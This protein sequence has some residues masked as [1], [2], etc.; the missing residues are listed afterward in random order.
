M[1]RR[2]F[3][4]AVA[5]GAV[6]VAGCGVAYA[7]T[8][9]ASGSYRTAAV[10]L[11]DVDETV[12]L[13]GT[14]T[15]SARRDLSFGV[16]GT[17]ATVDVAAG[18]VVRSGATLAT[19]DATA[20]RADVTQARAALAKAKAQL[21][22]DQTSQA[23]TVTAA[24]SSSEPATTAKKPSA[25]SG[26]SKDSSSDAPSKGA[27][28]SPALT[29]ALARL[30]D[31]QAVVTTAQTAATEAIAAAKSA[32]AAQVEACT[33]AAEVTDPEPAD[34]EEP[35][36]VDGTSLS[37]E[38]TDALAS[39]QDAQDVVAAKQDVL[40]SA[41]EKLTATLTDAVKTV[42]AS[43]T[44]TGDEQQSSDTP[45][46]APETTSPTT[47]SSGGASEDSGAGGGAGTG[48]GGGATVTA[49]TLAKDQAAIDTARAQLAEAR[50]Q[51][52]A[53]DLTA[54]FAGE[55]LSVTV[56]PGDTVGASDAV[57]VMVGDGSTT[58]T[59]TVTLDQVSDI[60]KGQKAQVTPAGASA[61]VTGTV[62]EIGLL[63]DT[64]SETSTFPVT[65]DL[66]GDVAAPE[67]STAAISL[68]VG[69]ASNVLTVPSSAVTTTGRTMV[70]V[71]QDGTP[72]MT[73]VTVGVV[74]QRRTEITDG[75]DEGQVVVLA[76]L[77][78]SL[79][80][81][82]GSTTRLP[83]SGSGFGGGGGVPGGAR[84]QGGGRG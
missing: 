60:A 21:E 7:Q 35:A 46:A 25:S 62:T 70:T 15:A 59:T 41:L 29:K 22:S 47:G 19:L 68:V 10:A 32:L 26:T 31:Q 64:G 71:L 49:A 63:P 76:S 16:S 51:R 75:L 34:D 36:P 14:I 82:D 81:G 43:D 73:P 65:I 74:G 8:Q 24:T 5:A 61:P 44:S 9:G 12:A 40:Q 39:A 18:D 1:R 67:G 50:Q 53:A 78:A 27:T 33:D 2:P 30:K 80:S 72:T 11:G 28:T 45:A 38:C 83:G 84:M 55:I 13:A 17:V 20:L 23:A 6:L 58:A 3:M 56:T 48:G 77:D 57:I 37:T 4:V 52:A 66:D 79:P 42:G 54:P 69:T